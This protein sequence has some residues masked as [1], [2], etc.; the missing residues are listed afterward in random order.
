M[1]EGKG[2]ELSEKDRE[3]RERSVAPPLEKNARRVWSRAH[4]PRGSLRTTP[5]SGRG[6]SGTK[7]KELL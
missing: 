5:A 3:V 4:L 2:F 7:I 1:G 6:K